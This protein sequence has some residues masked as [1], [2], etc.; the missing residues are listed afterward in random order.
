MFVP[1]LLG[2]VRVKDRPEV[3]MVLRLDRDK[4][5]ADLFLPGSGLVE[6][7]VHWAML[8][9]AWDDRGQPGSFCKP[10]SASSLITPFRS[11]TAAITTE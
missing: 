8:E 11:S 1:L 7:G 3:F 10:V 4:Q 5:T 6:R 2:L 9:D